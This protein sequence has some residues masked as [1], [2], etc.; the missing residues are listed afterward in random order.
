M[1]SIINLLNKKWALIVLA[2]IS[3]KPIR[4][5]QLL[6]EIPQISKASLINILKF[7]EKEGL[8]KKETCN[9]TVEPLCSSWHYI[10]ENNTINGL[11]SV[12][13]KEENNG[14]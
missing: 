4:T 10:C 7:L 3:Q 5:N 11:I 12:L 14:Y 1:K 9:I 2:K 8:I 13:E 6:N